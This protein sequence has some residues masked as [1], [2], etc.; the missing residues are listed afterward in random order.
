MKHLSRIILPHS[1]WLSGAPQ[2]PETGVPLGDRAGA[3][4][5]VW[6]IT[7]TGANGQMQGIWKAKQKSIMELEQTAQHFKALVALSEDP[8]S[9]PS[10]HMMVVHNNL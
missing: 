10:T 3:G 2:E 7:C 6:V 5:S 9:I 8:G 4:P 1:A